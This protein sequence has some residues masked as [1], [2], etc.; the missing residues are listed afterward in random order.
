[1][2]G[3]LTRLLSLTLP[4]SLPLSSTLSFTICCLSPIPHGPHALRHTSS[5]IALL[6]FASATYVL[7]SITLNIWSELAPQVFKNK[8]KQNKKNH[9]HPALTVRRMTSWAQTGN[10]SKLGRSDVLNCV[11]NKMQS[12]FNN[13]LLNPPWLLK[14]VNHWW[15]HFTTLWFI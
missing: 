9:C 8:T 1:M 4:P 15:S 10:R 6:C 11:I 2:H 7:I 5:G 3:E 12:Y 14:C 13:S